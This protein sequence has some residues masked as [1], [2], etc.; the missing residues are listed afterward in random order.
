[1]TGIKKA[2]NSS[3]GKNV[4]KLESSYT[5]GGNIK[6]C[7]H[8]GNSLAVPQLNMELPYDLAIPFT[9][10]YS[11]E[12]KTCLQR[13][14]YTSIY[15]IIILRSYYLI[16][17]WVCKTNEKFEVLKDSNLGDTDSGGDLKCALGKTK[18]AEAFK[19]KRTTIY[20]RTIETSLIVWT[21]HGWL[22][23]KGVVRSRW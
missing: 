18:K 17:I 16:K 20:N 2:Y 14:L 22:I 1:M 21:W 5:T 15:S 19:G 6:W 11:G 23:Q 13:N 4:E 12:V 9:G 7:S 10:I 3:V 8:F